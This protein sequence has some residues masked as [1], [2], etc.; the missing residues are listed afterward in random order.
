MSSWAYRGTSLDSLGIVTLVSDSFKMPKRRG[1]NILIPFLE[2]RIYTEKRFDERSMGLGLEIT[3][4]TLTAL[5]SKMDV[6]KTLL[7]AE[8]LGTL[9]E[10][11]ADLSVRTIQAEFTEDLNL[12]RISPLCVRMLLE[13][14]MP[15]PFFRGSVFKTDT[16]TIDATPE[17]YTFN[18]PG[19]VAERNPKIV[20]TGPLSNITITNLT[21]GRTLSYNAT[22][23]SPRVV[24]IETSANGGYVATND[25]GANVIGNVSHE[26]DSALFVLNAGDNSLSVVDGTHTTGTVKIEFYPPYL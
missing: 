17:T 4:D 11:L 21:N 6:V 25:L 8:G 3:E 22:I 14:I 2:G 16:H 12:T 18:N 9:S 26:G 24:T 15:T 19:T 1:E 5:E 20:L 13:F 7:G 23:A 10:T